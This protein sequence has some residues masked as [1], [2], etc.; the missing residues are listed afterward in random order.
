MIIILS[1]Y[2]CSTKR[3]EQL[4]AFAQA[5]GEPCL[6]FTEHAEVA[7]AVMYFCSVPDIHKRFSRDVTFDGSENENNINNKAI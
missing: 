3:P 5:L 6:F 4:F 1:W 7:C 2:F